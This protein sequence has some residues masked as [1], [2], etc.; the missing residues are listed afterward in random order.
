MRNLWAWVALGGS[1][2]AQE[3]APGEERE[4][5]R[6]EEIKEV[7]VY[8][9]S[10]LKPLGDFESPQSVDV[11]TSGEIQERRLSR[12][13]PEALKESPGVSVQRTGPAQGSPFIRGFTGFR[14]VMLVDGIR[15]NNSVFREGPNQYGA[16]VDPFL[17]DR[18]ELIRGPSSVLYGSDSIGGT[19]LVFTKEPSSF[20]AGFHIHERTFYRYA[21]ADDSHSVRQEVWG[22]L[23]DFGWFL[24]GT[25]R[26]FND[27][28]GGR[29]MGTME[30]TGYDEYDA[31]LKFVWKPEKGS[32]LVLAVQ[33]HRTDDAARWHSTMFSRE[34]H[35]TTT[36]T[37]LRRDFDQERDLYY[38]QYHLQS[39]G[40]IVDALK[41]GISWQVGGEKEVRVRSSGAKNVREFDLDTL[42]FQFQAG[43]QTPVGYFTAGMEFY[44]DRVDTSGYDRSAG[45]V[46]T[47]YE[48]GNWADDAT[49]DLWGVYLQDEFRVGDLEVIGGI[50][51]SRADV[52]TD[53]VDP[54]P[55]DTVIPDSLDERYQAVTGSLR[56]LYRV[57]ENWNA[58]AGWGMGF[59]A[60]SLDDTTAINFVLSGSLDLPAED[61]DP[62]K[63]HTFELGVRA[64]YPVWEASAFVFYTILD[65]FIQR[66]PMGD[67]NGDGITDFTKRNFSEG[68]VYGV[69][70]AILFRLTEEI[71][72]F[73]DLGYA[74][75]EVDQFLDAAGTVK[76]EQPLAKVGPG[77]IHLGVR[78]E[79]K[80]TG[81]WV[82][83]LFTATRHQHHLSVSDGADTQRIPPGGTPGY[84]VFTLRGG[85]KVNEQVTVTAA[86]ENLADRDY[87]QHGSGVNEPGTNAVLGLDVRF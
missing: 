47:V 48:R 62:E 67:Y 58:I 50:R 66:V 37:D 82:E 53:G 76:S 61:L 73:G 52:K 38:L 6:G 29:H 63:T 84:A 31:D 60:P 23:D 81:V 19:V 57:T 72:F 12:S 16:T 17:I 59:R 78:Y 54:G 43:K 87:R 34:W 39:E 79:P 85:W 15:L 41:A 8:G 2:W 26:D 75:G 65:D 46:L 83:G 68:Y 56:L 21:S 27:I 3:P 42:G 86:V 18:L 4:S 20:D 11:I 40:G 77:T 71:R 9:I 24:G 5:K 22:N 74:K 33:R 44:R 69:E 70:G 32:K 28:V 25:Y 14:N 30:G 45:G 80:D 55:G 36:G 1:L 35:G 10:P 64:R 13:T 49:Y 51:F 7:R